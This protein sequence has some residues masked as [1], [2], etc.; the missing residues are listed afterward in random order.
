M[1]AFMDKT[2][3]V[4]QMC[5]WI[6]R[7]IYLAIPLYVLAVLWNAWALKMGGVSLNDSPFKDRVPEIC[8]GHAEKS[9]GTPADRTLLDEFLLRERLRRYDLDRLVGSASPLFACVGYAVLGG[10]H[11]KTPGDAN[12]TEQ[13]ID[14]T[15]KTVVT[16]RVEYHKVYLPALEIKK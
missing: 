6:R 2:I 8:R 10:I 7:V 15:G 12:F 9:F 4:R 3:S 11:A 13:F 5:R 16:V 1:S 14:S